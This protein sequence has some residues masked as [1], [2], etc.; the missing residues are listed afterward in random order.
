MPKPR[1][2]GWP[3]IDDGPLLPGLELFVRTVCRER[4]M[5]RTAALQ[6]LAKA[7]SDHC[8]LSKLKLATKEGVAPD[9]VASRWSEKLAGSFQ[10]AH[11][12]ELV[13]RQWI[14]SGVDPSKFTLRPLN[15]DD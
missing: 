12:K 1:K 5:S 4:A 6:W 8:D 2:G 13:P 15:K 3:A 10:N 14:D 7:L 9:S 11:V